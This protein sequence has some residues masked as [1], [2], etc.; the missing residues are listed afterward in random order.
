MRGNIRSAWRRTG[1]RPRAE[2]RGETDN[3]RVLVSVE[4]QCKL[5]LAALLWQAEMDVM[6]YRDMGLIRNGVAVAELPRTD[7]RY[8]MHADGRVDLLDVQSLVEGMKSGYWQR[9]SNALELSHKV[10]AE[11]ILAPQKETT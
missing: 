7:K 4:Y 10:R 1:I 6:V 5:L 2:D 9:W 8:R 3:G 11:Y